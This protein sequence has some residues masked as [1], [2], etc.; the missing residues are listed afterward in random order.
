MTRS[1][2][3]AQITKRHPETNIKDVELAVKAILE[4]MSTALVKG[5]H[6]EVRGFGSFDLNFRPPRLGR[7]PKTGETVP[8]PAKG[9]PTSKQAKSYA[10]GW[11]RAGWTKQNDGG[12]LMTWASTKHNAMPLRLAQWPAGGLS[13]VVV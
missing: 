9:V 10:T 4:A 6:I 11:I 5:D 12:G 1:E 8:V 13:L 3:I 7:N 2:L